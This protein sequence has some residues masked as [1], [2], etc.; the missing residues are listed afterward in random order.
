[1][2]HDIANLKSQIAA[3]V[4]L[5]YLENLIDFN[6]HVSVRADDRVYINARPISRAAVEAK[7]I[8]AVD[9]RGTPIEGEYEPPGETMMH[10]AIY[11]FRRNVVSVAHLHPHYVTA[12]G[13]A[14]HKI[15]PVFILGS[16]FADGVPVYDDPDLIFTDAQG[17]AVAETLGTSRAA[18]L[19]GHGA[20]VVG[21]SLE[22]TF[23]ASV[24]LEENA[25][26]Q[27]AAARLG[28]VRAFTEDESRRVMKSLWKPK[29]VQKVWDFYISKG[30]LLGALGES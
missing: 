27:Y 26:K 23:T 4:R 9:L 8:V 7:H 16:I 25:K 24:Y 12:L 5:L 14:Q 30:R 18:V 3:A 20:V 21:A 1:M 29:T 17:D 10:T 19:R 15:V 11:R 2:T 28:H 13:I 22:E 6:G